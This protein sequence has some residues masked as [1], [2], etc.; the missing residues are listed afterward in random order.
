MA[1]AGLLLPITPA[2]RLDLGELANERLDL[3]A[4]PGRANVGDK[5]LTLVS[6]ALAGGDCTDDADV[7]RAG[8][9]A[10]ILEHA[11]F[12]NPVIELGMKH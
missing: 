2:D 7:L 11:R 8:D 9:T 5:L 4:K 12:T 3:G 6:P 1:N 10:R